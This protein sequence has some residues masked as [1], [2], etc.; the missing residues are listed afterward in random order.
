M[1]LQTGRSTGLI[2]SPMRE[3]DNCELLSFTVSAEA[4]FFFNLNSPSHMR[5]LCLIFQWK[6]DLMSFENNTSL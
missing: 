4:A 5:L 1:F 3:R 2:K 6:C